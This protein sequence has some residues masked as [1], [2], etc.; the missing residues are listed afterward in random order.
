MNNRPIELLD[1]CQEKY[2]L[3]R[4]RSVS[5]NSRIYYRLCEFD[6]ERDEWEA[7]WKLGGIADGVN[8]TMVEAF[9][10]IVTTFGEAVKRGESRLAPTC[11]AVVLVVSGKGVYKIQAKDGRQWNEFTDE[12]K[13]QAQEE[14]GQFFPDGFDP[15]EIVPTRMVMAITLEGM[16]REI[17]VA[18]PGL[19][20]I[21]ERM[22][23]WTQD[24]NDTIPDASNELDG[25]LLSLFT[26][27]QIVNETVRQGRSF[28]ISGLLQTAS[29]IPEH[30]GGR[31]M[32][33][34]L[35]RLVSMGVENGL[36][37]LSDLSGSEDD[38]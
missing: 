30:L 31:E 10:Q 2:G 38:N 26:F 20:P 17:T 13:R 8:E 14:A 15:T 29:N 7:S 27:I 23:E 5:D 12:E 32:T 33:A 1:E 6:R 28:D 34:L 16:A 37:D 22:E 36:F 4:L 3:D 35:L 21:V 11:D 24:G 18:A 9:S 19:E 25:A